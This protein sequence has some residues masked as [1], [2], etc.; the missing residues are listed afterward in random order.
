M[1]FFLIVIKMKMKTNEKQDAIIKQEVVW[2]PK[3]RFCMRLKSWFCSGLSISKILNCS[4]KTGWDI[5]SQL[6]CTNGDSVF[7]Y[8]PASCLCRRPCSEVHRKLVLIFDFNKLLQSKM[9]KLDDNILMIF[10]DIPWPT[11]VRIFLSQIVFTN[12]FA[13][14]Q[15]RKEHTEIHEHIIGFRHPN[16]LFSRSRVNN[17]SMVRPA[18]PISLFPLICK[19]TSLFKLST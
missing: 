6:A 2:K 18:A 7:R 19:S 8:A 15:S 14:N 4:V 10:T 9:I 13:P 11:S 17:L 12:Q 3:L 16:L 5:P 1:I